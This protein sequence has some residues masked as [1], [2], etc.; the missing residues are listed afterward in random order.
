MHFECD[1]FNIKMIYTC[2]ELLETRRR[3][4]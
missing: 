1:S 2:T 4:S 3:N